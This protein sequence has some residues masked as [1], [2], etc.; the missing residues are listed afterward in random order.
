MNRAS[1]PLTLYNKPAHTARVRDLYR[2]ILKNSKSWSF[3]EGVWQEDA[4]EIR[5]EF[6][7][8]MS[9]SR[10][11]VVEQLIQEAEERLK[12]YEHPDPYIFPTHPGGS[13]YQRN[14]PIPE[15]L[16]NIYQPWL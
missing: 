6:N 7:K 4:L 13:M 2:R 14:T 8:H 5:R 10:P 12:K 15:R 11:V 3:V 9:E 1:K 16:R